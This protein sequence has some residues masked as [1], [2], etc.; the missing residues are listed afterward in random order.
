MR[1]PGL[2]QAAA[3]VIVGA[4]CASQESPLPMEPVAFDV[5]VVLSRV[6]D[7]VGLHSTHMTGSEEV[8]SIASLGQGQATFRLGP[9]GTTLHYTLIVSNILNVTQSHIHLGPAGANGPIVA[10]LYPSAPPLRLIPGR[11]QGMLAEGTITAANLM[12][13]LA[14]GSLEALVAA[15]RD[16][17]TYVN[18]H[19][20]QNMPG[21]IRGQIK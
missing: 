6:P 3:L 19:T 1:V 17:G 14:G 8:P 13:P 16:G 10:W 9:D 12:G 15:I 21:E 18:V 7:E 2:F 4:A 20:S 5:E 11:S